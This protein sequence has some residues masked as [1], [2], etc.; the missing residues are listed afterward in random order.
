[1]MLFNLVLRGL[2]YHSGGSCGQY[3]VGHWCS[4][5]SFCAVLTRSKVF[6][7][8]WNTSANFCFLIFLTAISPLWLC[9]YLSIRIKLPWGQH[10]HH[11]LWIVCV[12]FQYV[13]F[14]VFQSFGRFFCCWFG[15]GERRGVGFCC[16]WGFFESCEL[17]SSIS[18]C[19]T[20]HVVVEMRPQKG[21][22]GLVEGLSVP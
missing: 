4:F 2:W 13:G 9:G 20:L 5:S 1:M 12:I 19:S 3:D 15:G 10:R 21:Q 17:W 6:S 18:T 7:L 16:C 11:F 14:G 22:E 8:Q